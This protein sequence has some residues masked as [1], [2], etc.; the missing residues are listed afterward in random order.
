MHAKRAATQVAWHDRSCA[1]NAVCDHRRAKC[2]RFV[3]HPQ[4]AGLVSKA[5]LADLRRN[6]M[7]KLP[8]ELSGGDESPVSKIPVACP[9]R[10]SGP[11]SLG[12][13]PVPEKWSFP[14]GEM[15]PLPW[16]L[17]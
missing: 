12:G 2:S 10:G 5:K 3:K 11:L 13:R 15:N 1:R 17:G 14:S 8:P 7:A 9:C 6:W 4:R 16:L